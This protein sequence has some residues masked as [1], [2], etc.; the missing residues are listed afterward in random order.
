MF[1]KM[2]CDSATPG[3]RRRYLREFVPAMVGY[4]V[5]LIVSMLL[6][7]HVEDHALRAV[8][9]LLPVVP[10]ALTLRA[11]VR[12]IRDADELQRRIELEAVSLATALVSLVYMAGGFLQLAKVID[13]PSGV[14][15]IWV[16]PLLCA[17][18]G[19]LKA[20]V[21]RRFR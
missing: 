1:R 3:L 6:L 19:L 15:M 8:I 4:V 18:Y 12:Y 2:S 16:F 17:T 13:I 21:A 14:A 5:L 7:K 9:A 10:I 11:I 20:V